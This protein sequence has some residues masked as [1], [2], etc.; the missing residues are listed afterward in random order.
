MFP[1]AKATVTEAI[2]EGSVV[3]DNQLL[4][5][6]VKLWQCHNERSLQVR[7]KTGSLLN[8][9]LGAPTERQFR[10]QR[11]LAQAA[12]R[13]EIAQSELNRMRWF[14]HFSKDGGSFWGD[15]EPGSRT[16]TKFK[17]I[18]P[19]LKAAR[20]GGKGQQS[21]SGK[22]TR[23]AVVNG[24]FKSLDSATSKLRTD[25][26]KV[27]G[28][29]REELIAKLRGFVSAVSD[30]TGIRLRLAETADEPSLAVA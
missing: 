23:S 29:K 15:E 7:L 21:S 4:D 10:G 30:S 19:G 16:W 24:I 5:K 25:N 28:A 14:A 3:K 18:L 17:E 1:M 22:K 2:E 8:A 6:L 13:L 27:D 26:F 20:N 9:R 12:E 11:V